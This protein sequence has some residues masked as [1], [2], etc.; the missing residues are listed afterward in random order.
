M[1]WKCSYP[2]LKRFGSLDA[3][4][5]LFID[6]SLGNAMLKAKKQY[7]WHIDEELVLRNSNDPNGVAMKLFDQAAE[8]AGVDQTLRK[9]RSVKKRD[10]IEVQDTPA[11]H[12]DFDF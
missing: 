11:G 3:N 1:P 8:S 10:A 4:F 2:P 9:I 7:N 5:D 12:D 6:L